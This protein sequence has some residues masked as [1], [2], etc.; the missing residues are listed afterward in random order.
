MMRKTK[1]CR[2]VDFIDH[3]MLE[4][5]GADGRDYWV[6]DGRTNRRWKTR[7][8]AKKWALNNGYTL[9]GEN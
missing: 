1:I 3:F 9:E 2:I 7:D 8:G 6:D 5:H 4:E